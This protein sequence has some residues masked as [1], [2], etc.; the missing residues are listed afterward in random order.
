MAIGGGFCPAP[1][2]L[3]GSAEEGWPAA[4]HARMAADVAAASRALPFAVITVTRDSLGDLSPYI[5]RYTSQSAGIAANT[6]VLSGD[7]PTPLVITWPAAPEDELGE[8]RSLRI[9]GVRVT[10]HLSYGEPTVEITAPNQVAIDPTD[11]LGIDAT[12]SVYGIWSPPRIE[13]YGGALDKRD[14]QTE[15]TPYAFTWY[16]EHTAALG[17]A[18][19]TGMRGSVHARKLALARAD[20]AVTRSEE[21]ARANCTAATADALLPE[22]SESLAVPVAES[23]PKWLVRQRCAAKQ[24]AKSGGNIPDLEAALIQLLGDRFVAVHT[25]D[26]ADPDG[27]WPDSYDL[28]G[29]VWCSTRSKVLVE[30]TDPSDPKDPVFLNLMNVQFVDLMDRLVPA[31]V[32]FDWYTTGGFYLDES[33]LDFD[34]L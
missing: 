14:C 18:Y 20:A 28:G 25:F 11:G 34:G 9:T 4:N 33:L 26:D 24:A 1:W 21:R 3:G 12:I 29:G 10:R 16:Q 19:G 32:V 6:P 15:T 17:S 22:W 8:A 27:T 23:D 31:W 2:R 30:V 7:S 13:D 5:S